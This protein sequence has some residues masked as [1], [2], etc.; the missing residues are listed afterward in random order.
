MEHIYIY[1]QSFRVTYSF[2]N[3]VKVEIG[4]FFLVLS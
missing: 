3:K 4:K 1:M 2:E